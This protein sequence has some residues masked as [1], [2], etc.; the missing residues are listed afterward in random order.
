[1]SDLFD[2]AYYDLPHSPRRAALDS[3]LTEIQHNTHPLTKLALHG[4]TDWPDA[5][6]DDPPD[7]EYRCGTCIH[8]QPG[9]WPSCAM[10]SSHRSDPDVEPWWPACILYDPNPK[11]NHA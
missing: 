7:L 11:E 6:P 2:G 10:H 9:R 1:M 5:S 4:R 8:L 3:Q